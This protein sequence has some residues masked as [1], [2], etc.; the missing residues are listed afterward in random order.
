MDPRRPFRF[1]RQHPRLLSA[2]LITLV[3]TAALPFPLLWTRLLVGWCLGV[4]VYVALVFWRSS[5]ATPERLER[6]AAQ[7]G[8]DALTVLLFAILATA[9]SFGAVASVIF[10]GE[11]QGEYRALH[12]VLAGL[13]MFSSWLFVQVV[14]TVHYARLY[15]A[16][17][18]DGERHGGLDFNGDDSPDFWDFFYFSVTIGATSQTSDTDITAKGMRRVAILQTIYAYLFNTSVLALVVN[19]AASLIAN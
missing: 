14:F 19:M 10:G 9:A 11:E 2:V 13:T 3:M 1:L 6:E 8:D 15:Y 4:S 16:R 18:E 7:L 12:L 5:A 17:G